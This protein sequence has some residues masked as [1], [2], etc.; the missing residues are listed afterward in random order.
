MHKEI[1]ERLARCY[2]L[3]L[4]LDTW[5]SPGEVSCKLM[6]FSPDCG[7]WFDCLALDPDAS[8]PLVTH[9]RFFM[10]EEAAC[11]DYLAS[12]LGLKLMVDP[13][14]LPAFEEQPGRSTASIAS[15]I[16]CSARE[17]SRAFIDIPRT[18][19]ELEIKIDLDSGESA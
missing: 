17:S 4:E 7:C 8:R 13:M 11:E 10:T 6:F 18:L 16:E 3:K 9:S 12:V 14:A 2:G 15:S 1:L 19:E 5:T